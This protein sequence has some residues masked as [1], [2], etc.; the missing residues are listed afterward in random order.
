MKFSQLGIAIFILTMVTAC[1]PFR[2][3]PSPQPEMPKNYALQSEPSSQ[4]LPD[5]WWTTFQDIQLNQLEEQLFNTN[6]DLRQAFYRL[7]QVKA[8]ARQTHAS[9]LPTM[10]LNGST[11]RSQSLS[12]TGESRSTTS[13]LSIS[14]A[15]EIDLWN[16]LSD[17]DQATQAQILAN[18]ENVKALFLSLSAQL[19]QQYFLVQEQHAHIRLLETQKKRSKLLLNLITE[20]YQAGLLTASSVYQAERNLATIEAQLPAYETTLK[21]AENNISVLLGSAPGTIKLRPSELPPISKPITIGLP[22][23][24]LIRR[25]DIKQALYQL[26]ALDHTLAAAIAE[27]LPGLNLTA[28]LG[29]AANSL[30]SGDVNGTIWSLV[31]SLSQP[32]FDGD[33]RQ[34]TVE[35]Q[36]ALLAEQL[37][38]TRQALLTALQEVEDS[39]TSEQNYALRAEQ[40]RRQNRANDNYRKASLNNYRFGLSDSTNWL[41]SE[42][43][44]LGILSAQ[45]SNQR[46]W[47]NQRI[48]LAKALGGSWMDDQ[49]ST[50]RT[51][52]REPK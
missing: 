36:K 31:L 38:A 20:R 2:P 24:L 47:L 4:V 51:S 30:T 26:N 8:Q 7:E 45:I 17:Q 43:D 16:K 40:L 48:I 3:A 41:N 15:Y 42:I 32:L 9:R 39:L 49:L 12:A 22:A 29:K 21:Q 6:L 23:D 37:A 1:N 5:K 27:R 18:A 33:R 46:L 10:T 28:T 50:L 13:S 35:Q 14:A 34:A 19:A 11:G 25:P 44:Q 52:L